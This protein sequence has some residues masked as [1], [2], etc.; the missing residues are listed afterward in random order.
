MFWLSDGMV[1]DHCS[2][3]LVWSSRGETIGVESVPLLIHNEDGAPSS[4]NRAFLLRGELFSLTANSSPSLHL[5]SSDSARPSTNGI[6]EDVSFYAFV[7]PGELPST[8]FFWNRGLVVTMNAL[9]PARGRFGGIG[10]NFISRDMIG[11]RD[12]DEAVAR[13]SVS[14]QATGHSYNMVE[15]GGGPGS[16]R[17]RLVNLETA[18]DVEGGGAPRTSLLEVLPGSALF[19]ANAYQRLDVE[20]VAQLVVSSAH[21]EARARALPVPD[22]AASMMRVMGDRG[23]AAGWNIYRTAQPP[24]SGYTLATALIDPAARRAFILTGRPGVA[25]PRTT[26]TLPLD[27]W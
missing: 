13:A 2:D 1:F 14:G 12:V 6:R 18:P 7:Y 27:L 19:H 16:A 20:Q 3:Y 26:R 24:D 9:Y 22:D 5:P 8:A 21:R 11:A 25:D 15:L 10:R 23:D 4:R 17:P